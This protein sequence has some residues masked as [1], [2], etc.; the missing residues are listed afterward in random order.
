MLKR[1]LS[2]AP[3]VAIAYCVLA[4]RSNH[5]DMK[6]HSTG[7]RTILWGTVGL[8]FI[9][10][11]SN[12]C[13]NKGDNKDTNEKAEQPRMQSASSADPGE[14]KRYDELVAKGKELLG[15]PTFIGISEA[16]RCFRE[17]VILLPD[18]AEYSVFSN[19]IADVRGRQEEMCDS[20]LAPDLSQ[21]AELRSEINKL[22]HSG[23][24]Q[25]DA[26]ITVV[27]Q[28]L[29]R[30]DVEIAERMGSFGREAPAL[31]KLI[32]A[33]VLDPSKVSDLR[34]LRSKYEKEYGL[35][36]PGSSGAQERASKLRNVEEAAE[37]RK[38]S[39]QHES[40]AEEQIARLREELKRLEEL[41]RK[42]EESLAELEDK[43]K[44][45]IERHKEQEKALD[46]EE[47]REREEIDRK[48][49]NK[50]QSRAKTLREGLDLHDR[51]AR[52][53]AELR[54]AEREER[55]KARAEILMARDELATLR[56][57]L[58]AAKDGSQQV[59]RQL[60]FLRSKSGEVGGHS[61]GEVLSRNAMLQIAR[62]L[63]AGKSRSLKDVL[64]Q[65]NDLPILEACWTMQGITKA[66]IIA[67]SAESAW[68]KALDPHATNKALAY[69]KVLRVQPRDPLAL[70]QFRLYR[71]GF[72]PD[73]MADAKLAFNPQDG[74]IAISSRD[75][76]DLKG[77]YLLLPMSYVT[78]A[79]GPG[80][81]LVR[82]GKR[83]RKLVLC[84]SIDKASQFHKYDF[85]ESGL[86][87][88]LGRCQGFTYYETALGN[89]KQAV[90]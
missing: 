52:K 65:E 42:S 28:K 60:T 35:F 85:N 68:G 59:E 23:L 39:A 33:F 58:R 3:W 86:Y 50:E 37:R 10:T 74:W 14:K 56:G 51:F 61:E 7:K 49:T 5:G 55:K 64:C 25:D 84:K 32:E 6:K 30:L 17:A 9:A 38:T 67:D 53:H 13:D 44:R 8:M 40:D 82:F 83:G 47:R 20:A 48:Y 62:D 54:R 66:R 46:E 41:E 80:T 12:G 31:F 29:A 36:T 76:N 70:R 77:H 2:K 69:L 21:K 87:N 4:E 34:R 18:E 11:L 72:R 90:L 16:Q 73:S 88:L 15:A 79:L 81:C 1:F 45:R 78:Q 19:L 57:K 89:K 27:R 43:D 75:V 63:S 24:S 22:E 26:A 71:E